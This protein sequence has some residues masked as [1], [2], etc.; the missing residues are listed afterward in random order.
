MNN[1]KKN[2]VTKQMYIYF[3]KL[4]KTFYKYIKKNSKTR[5]TKK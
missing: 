4:K 1:V 2:D 3:Y 5:I